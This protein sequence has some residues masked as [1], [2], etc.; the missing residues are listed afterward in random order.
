MVT[1]CTTHPPRAY[2]TAVLRRSAFTLIELITVMA[3]MMLILGL[4][5]AAF[6]DIGR[7][8]GMRGAV[9]QFK[10]AMSLARQNAITRRQSTFLNYGNEGE[11]RGYYFMTEGKSGVSGGERQ[12]TMSFLPNGILFVNEASPFSYVEFKL[13]GT[14]AKTSTFGRD[15]GSSSYEIAVAEKPPNG[16]TNYFRV[17]LQTGRIK[18]LRDTGQL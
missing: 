3:I 1:P 2:R 10:A 8:A 14:V 11:D 17:F 18:V 7:G 16:A 13:D 9:L 6:K 12:G 4:S 15:K 5:M